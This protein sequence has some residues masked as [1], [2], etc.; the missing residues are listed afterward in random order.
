MSVTIRTL[1]AAD[2]INAAFRVFLRS[3]VGLGFGDIDATTITES[4]RYLGAF[5]GDVIVGS[6]DAYTSR[7]VVPGGARVAH[8]A[9]THIGVLP[10]HRRRGIVTELID[11]QLAEIAARGEVV[12][13]L[14]A[15]EAGI[16][17]RFGYGIATFAREASIDLRRSVLRDSVPD[18]GSV[19]L[20]DRDVTNEL[21]DGIYR[22]AAWVGAIDRPAGWW[23]LREL[24]RT[25][26]RVDH[27]VA[28]H[29]VDGIDDGYVIY[30]PNDTDTWF[31][32]TERSVTVVDVVAL[33]DA[34]RA[35]LWRHVISLDLVDKVLWPAVALDD[36]LPLAVVDA[37]SVHLGP[38]RDETW[39]RI[40]DVE[41][42]LSARTYRD[43]D[44][45]VVRVVDRQIDAN[46]ATFEIGPKGVQ[47]SDARPDATVDV[48][49]LATTY[50]G[51]TR[52]RQL[53][54]V[55]RVDVHTATAVERL[56]GLFVT[57]AEPFSGTIF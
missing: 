53:A 8:A 48:A 32:S 47:R 29:S 13:T 30:R 42:A 3:M 22:R 33:N 50:L 10:T 37:R 23:R 9:V 11:R 57:D 56:D 24:Q 36:P 1:H 45:V 15:S 31:T 18:I 17:E 2:E 55:G 43:H 16:Y 51:G 4:G 21:L 44:P 52:W 20:V 35:G 19:R 49:T 54:A 27:Y 46:N 41:A 25:G 38:A 26:S 5:D 40:V 6:A 28:V 7:L 39:L 14:R 34:A 12:A